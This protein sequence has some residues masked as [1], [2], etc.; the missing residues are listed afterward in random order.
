MP[1][2]IYASSPGILVTAA[3]YTENPAGP[4][5]LLPYASTIGTTLTVK[6]AAGLATAL[7]PITIST[8][9]DAYYARTLSTSLISSVQI[10]TAGG[11]VT[12]AALQPRTYTLLDAPLGSPLIQRRPPNTLRPNYEKIS[13]ISTYTVTVLSSLTLEPTVS[14]DALL[15]FT[16]PATLTADFTSTLARSAVQTNNLYSASSVNPF[17]FLSTGSISTNTLFVS[18]F[19]GAGSYTTSN[20][21]G[22]GTYDICGTTLTTVGGNYSTVRGGTLITDDSF[23]VGGDSVVRGPM[24]TL[25]AFVVYGSGGLSIRDN[26]TTQNLS[27]G[28]HVVRGQATHA[29][30]LFVASTSILST[31]SVHSS[32]AYTSSIGIGEPLGAQSQPWDVSGSMFVS[33]ELRN[34]GTLSTILVSTASLIGSTF[35]LFDRGSNIFSPLYVQGTNLFY[36]GTQVGSA[37]ATDY[38]SSQTRVS[39]FL[40]TKNLYASTAFVGPSTY[41]TTFNLEVNGGIKITDT[42]GA[43][44]R[45]AGGA[46]S[47]TTTLAWSEDGI[48]WNTA[49]AGSGFTDATYGLAWNGRQWLAL[50]KDSGNQTIEVSLDGKS[51]SASGVT[52]AFTGEGHAAAWN[53][54]RWVAVGQGTGTTTIKTSTDGYTWTNAASGGFSNFG[55]DVAWNGRLWLAVGDSNTNSH[56]IQYSYDASNWSNA[57]SGSFDLS[58]S[59]LAWNGRIWVAVGSATTLNAR[60]KWSANGLTWTDSS[61]STAFS[62]FGTDVVWSGQVFHATGSDTTAANCIKFSYDGS[63]WSNSVAAPFTG[64]ANAITYDG[65]K[66]IAAGTDSTATSQI[67]Y[68]YNGRSWTT[69]TGPPFT[70]NGGA[71]AVAYGYDIVPRLQVAG[72]EFYDGVQPFLRSTN[73]IFTQGVRFTSTGTTITHSTSM[74]I[75]NTLFINPPTGVSI[76]IDPSFVGSSIAL[77]VYGSTFSRNATPLKIG[78]GSWI[79]VSDGRFKD[80]IPMPNMMIS[81]MEKLDNLKP[82]EYKMK[83]APSYVNPGAIARRNEYV[84]AL[85]ADNTPTRNYTIEK[86]NDIKHKLITI[87]ITKAEEVEKELGFV[88]ED[89]AV[90]IPEAIEP[91][92]IDG[93]SYLGLNYEQIQMVHLATTH[94]LMSTMEIQES[95][96]KGQDG[97]IE[98]LYAN[99]NLLRDLLQL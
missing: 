49:S 81:C 59:A 47:G 91:I 65:D 55:Y 67:D 37:G 44:L 21:T 10:T 73:T 42:P 52:G 25:G 5:V 13:T 30:N 80:N 14:L 66:W 61:G 15:S 94:A 56:S 18:T 32:A 69:A 41:R 33:A 31:L 78:G 46:G 57:T 48:T 8:I 68:S 72:L 76:N 6:D 1:Y 28:A 27:V 3:D 82:K 43:R 22:V 85:K 64:N 45:V 16:A 11:S 60:I 38:T 40:S 89:V 99:Y 95:T 36:A 87:D 2:N 20:Y 17:S 50:G 4:I 58:G 96:L 86:M 74:V 79:S 26:F 9:V 70:A 71:F 12:V 88:A 83:N 97:T 62:G 84:Q 90:A 63:I 7:S 24:S 75:N 39:S 34:A 77:L 23:R 19:I 53:G 29:S 98:L 54:S 51:W 92:E 93:Q 35:T